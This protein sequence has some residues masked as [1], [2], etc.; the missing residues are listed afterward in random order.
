MYNHRTEEEILG[1]D[2]DRAWKEFRRLI[3]IKA[4][5]DKI[6]FALKDIHR[7]LDKLE[8]YYKEKGKML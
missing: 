1:I 3:K 2:L 6:T 7:C 5:E 4:T 8:A